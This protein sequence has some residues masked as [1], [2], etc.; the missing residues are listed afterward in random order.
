MSHEDYLF[1]RDL[2]RHKY[3]NRADL[4]PEQNEHFLLL[5]N[6]GYLQTFAGGAFN[7]LP[8]GQRAMQDYLR[9]ASEKE[10]EA[11]CARQTVAS[12]NAISAALE[13][14]RDE[15]ADYKAQQAKQRDSDA[16]QAAVDKKKQL[17]HEYLV[18]A[19]T[20]ALTLF[21]EHFLD[22]VELAKLAF[23]SLVA[24]LK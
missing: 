10:A 23:E 9:T 6:M 2:A 18:A 11:R 22:I 5:E 14:T 17:R 8:A 13:Q 20:V 7:V 3:G 1:L 24:A 4:T 12:I 16:V 19:F 15:F 21:L